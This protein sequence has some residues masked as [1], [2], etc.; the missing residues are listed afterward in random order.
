MQRST[1]KYQEEPQKTFESGKRGLLEPEES[2]TPGEQ[3]PQDK[4]GSEG[5]PDTEAII[6]LDPAC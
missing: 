3:G 1:S 5:L 4:Q 6:L 2:R